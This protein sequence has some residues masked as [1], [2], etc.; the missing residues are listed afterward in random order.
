MKEPALDPEMHDERERTAIRDLQVLREAWTSVVGRQPT[1]DDESPLFLLIRSEAGAHFPIGPFT[2]L[3]GVG[4]FRQ[5]LDG[6][7][8]DA[9]VDTQRFEAIVYQT[10][11]P[12]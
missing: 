9:G 11:P 10:Y 12:K 1:H 2:D 7:L 6:A 4:S 8:Q 5:R 3:D